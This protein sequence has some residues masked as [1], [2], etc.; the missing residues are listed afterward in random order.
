MWASLFFVQ[1]FAILFTDVTCL[2]SS[3]VMFCRMW[4]IL[5]EN[6]S[7]WETESVVLGLVYVWVLIVSSYMGNKTS[8]FMMNAVSCTLITSQMIPVVGSPWDSG[9]MTSK[10]NKNKLQFFFIRLKV[11]LPSLYRLLR[12][13]HHFRILFM[14][15]IGV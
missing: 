4:I 7:V 11:S 12:T 9:S 10:K 6:D 1:F 15:H 5:T 3:V 13:Y 14:F 2:Q 8:G